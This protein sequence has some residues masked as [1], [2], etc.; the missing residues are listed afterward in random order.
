MAAVD[1]KIAERRL[2]I[3]DLIDWLVEDKMVSAED[4]DKLKKERR[5]FRGAQHP[6]AVIADQKLKSAQPPVAMNRSFFLA[7]RASAQAPTSGA[8]SRTAR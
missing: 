8:V 5:Y 3:P 6:L 4:A 1:P 7:A 2:T